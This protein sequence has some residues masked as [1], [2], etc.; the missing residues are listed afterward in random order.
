LKY[1]AGVLLQ[2]PP[3]GCSFASRPLLTAK[4]WRGLITKGKDT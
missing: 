1:A 2:V 3:G 4:K